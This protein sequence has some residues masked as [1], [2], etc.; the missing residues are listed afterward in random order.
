[1]LAASALDLVVHLQ[2]LRDSTRLVVEIGRLVRTGHELDVVPAWSV[3]SGVG[4]AGPALAASIAERGVAV[5]DLL[6]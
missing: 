4:A 2:R 1:M 3:R 5:P 6:R